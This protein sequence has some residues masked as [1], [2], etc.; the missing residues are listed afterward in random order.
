SASDQ[1]SRLFQNPV[2][3]ASRYIHQKRKEKVSYRDGIEL[4]QLSKGYHFRSIPA[5]LNV[6]LI[7]LDTSGK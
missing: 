5:Q 7:C 2:L 3:P 1:K 6:G 4:P